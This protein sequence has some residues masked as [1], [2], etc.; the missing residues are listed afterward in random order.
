MPWVLAICCPLAPPRSLWLGVELPMKLFTLDFGL[1]APSIASGFF[2][3]AVC[4]RFWLWFFFA[5][6][7]SCAI[8]KPAKLGL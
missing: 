5:K 3:L 1:L 4:G 8:A 7:D 6:C 2:V